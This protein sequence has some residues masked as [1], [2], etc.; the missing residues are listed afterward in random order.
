[1]A[2]YGAFKLGAL[3]PATFNNVLYT[4]LRIPN[5]VLVPA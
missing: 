3:A 1:M 4:D 2:T 5:L